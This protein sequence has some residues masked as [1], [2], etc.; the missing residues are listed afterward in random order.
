[1]LLWAACDGHDH[2][3]RINRVI[4]VTVFGPVPCSHP[5]CY[6]PVFY[7]MKGYVEG[8]SPSGV[9][10][11]YRTELWDNCKACWTIWVPAQLVNFS[12]VPRHLRIPFGKQQQRHPIAH[13]AALHCECS[14]AA[15]TVVLFLL[16]MKLR[17]PIWHDM[18]CC[19]PCTAVAGVSFAWTVVISVMRGA[20]DGTKAAAPTT[21]Q[22]EEAVLQVAQAAAEPVAA[23][24]AVVAPPPAAPVLSAGDIQGATATKTGL[25]VLVP[26]A[27][28]EATS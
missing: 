11:K 3:C 17:A 20:L 22:L 2:R 9:F 25:Q 7:G 26:R 24:S 21:A 4:C 19:C 5:F 18:L 15:E 10:E 6:F 27:H 1:M 23:D 28:A 16:Q 13:T 12:V 8:R 14:S